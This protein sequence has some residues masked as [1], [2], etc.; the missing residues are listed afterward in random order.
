MSIMTDIE[1]MTTSLYESS[2]L[3]GYCCKSP[4]IEVT[5]FF[6]RYHRGSGPGGMLKED[7]SEKPTFILKNLTA[8]RAENFF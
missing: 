5:S 3:T 6:E 8:M 2:V 7:V 4:L 1:Q